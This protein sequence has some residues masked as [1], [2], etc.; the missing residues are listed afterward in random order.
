V[1]GEKRKNQESREVQICVRM[2]GIISAH[3]G[4]RRPFA[5]GSREKEVRP[6]GEEG[7][8]RNKKAASSRFKLFF[9]IGTSGNGFCT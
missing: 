2:K 8:L 9:V 6:E 4:D 5:F 7:E 3:F 1:K